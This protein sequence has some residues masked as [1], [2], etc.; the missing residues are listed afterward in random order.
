MRMRAAVL[1]HQAPIES[2]PL[3]VEHVSR[4]APNRDE[5]LLQVEACG[6]CRTD[7]HVIEGD[8]TP[9]SLPVIPGHQIVGRVVEIG[10]GVTEFRVGDRAGIAWLRRV[11]GDCRYCLAERENLCPNAS[12]TG[13]SSNGGYAEFAVAPS[14][15]AYRLTESLPAA[16]LAPLLCAGII[17]YRALKRSN[18]RPGQRLGIF[19]F[20]NS[21]HVTIQIALHW[22]CQ[23][24]VATRGDRHQALALKMG[25]TCAADSPNAFHEKL[26]GAILFAPVGE[27][28]PVALRAL[29]RGGT[30][31]LAGIHL[32]DIPS[33]NYESELFYERT[34]TS[35]TANTRQDGHELLALAAD[36]PIRSRIEIFTLE[37]VNTALQRLRHDQINGAAVVR[38]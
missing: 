2:A 23:V 22:G 5:I 20:G 12:F 38:L 25:A 7:L 29:D 37:N 33:M 19:G 8:L 36:I 14:A 4:P 13:Y 6:C 32:S 24:Y 35:V 34:V 31:A 16:E 3:H 21:A 9:V 17:G 15:F 26:D 10:S 30:L 11:D 1:H 18:I 28:V 27:L